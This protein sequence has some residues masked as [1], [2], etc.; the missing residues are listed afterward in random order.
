M[1]SFMKK[2]IC[3]AVCALCVTGTM[4]AVSTVS[5]SG[6]DI[7]DFYVSYMEELVLR[8]QASEYAPVVFRAYGSG[9]EL[10]VMDY[11]NGF[12]YCYVPEFDVNGW[13]DLSEISYESTV[14]LSGGYV[15]DT[16]DGE[17]VETLYSW[18]DSGYLALR[19][20]PIN[21]DAYIISEIYE[22]GTVLLMTGDYVGSYGY[23]Y[24]PVLDMYG[25]VNT[26]YTCH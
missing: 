19:S 25:W 7:Q 8:D 11:L 21:E 12:G 9:Y 1:K 17:F 13:V 15:Y 3:A 26:D 18:V 5:A 24:V 10:H 4:G 22:N 23:C 6:H 14:D 20:A 2:V 16:D